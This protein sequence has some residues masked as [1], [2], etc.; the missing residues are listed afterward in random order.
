VSPVKYEL[1]FISQKMTFF[2]VT[3]VKTSNLTMTLQLF[4]CRGGV[5]AGRMRKQRRATYNITWYHILSFISLTQNFIGYRDAAM[6][7]M[8]R[9]ICGRSNAEIKQMKKE[10]VVLPI[11]TEDFEEALSRCRK[12]VSLSDVSKYEIWME[13]FGSY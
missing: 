7:S 11:T 12:S 8:R 10:D 13:E 6:M 2:I 3:A 1:G 5:G 9:K 4:K